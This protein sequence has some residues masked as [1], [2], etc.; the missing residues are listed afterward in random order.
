MGIDGIGLEGE[1]VGLR[2]ALAA[3]GE[4]VWVTDG[5]GPLAAGGWMT[6]GLT[7]GVGTVWGAVFGDEVPL[8]EVCFAGGVVRTFPRLPLPPAVTEGIAPPIPPV[9]PA[10]VGWSGARVLPAVVDSTE[11]ASGA[12]FGQPS[13]GVDGI[14][15]NISAESC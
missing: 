1:T 12:V 4:R 11:G 15:A 2:G 7:M 3:I 8:V 5:P 10:W 9:F 14:P 13:V 6:S